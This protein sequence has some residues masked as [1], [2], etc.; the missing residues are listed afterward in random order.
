MTMFSSLWFSAEV[1]LIYSA[2]A[3]HVNLLSDA[4]AAGF[5]ASSGGILIVTINSGVTLS[6]TTTNAINSGNFPANS[7]VTI[8]NNGTVSGYTGA[9][10]SGGAAG[11]V[12]GDAFNAEFTA[13]GSTWSIVNNGTWGGGGGGGGSGASRSTSYAGKGGQNYCDVPTNIGSAGAAG[14]LGA[15]GATGSNGSGSSVCVNYAA[16]A[17]GAAGYAVKKNGLTISTTGTFLGTVG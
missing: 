12:G 15:A 13:S 5:D 3:T 11:S 17:G 2:N 8:T 1:G 6:G 9:T 7:T 16:G 14:G 4:V 10:G